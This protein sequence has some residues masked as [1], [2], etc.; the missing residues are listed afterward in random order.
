M[1]GTNPSGAASNSCEAD[2]AFGLNVLSGGV[3]IVDK[4][5]G[6]TSHDVVAVI[7]GIAKT[8]RVGHGGTLDPM[9][10]GVLPVFI[11]RATK[12]AD[13]SADSDKEYIALMRLGL[14]TDTQDITGNVLE[15]CAE[16]PSFEET[17]AALDAFRGEVM[18]LPPMYS[19]VKVGGRKLYELAR[20]GVEVERQPRAV[21]FSKIELEPVDPAS[22]EYRLR[23]RCSKGGYI[24]TLCHD[25]GQ[26]LGCGAVMSG[27]RRTSAAGLDISRAVTLDS[28]KADGVL[29]HLLPVDTL[30]ERY[31]RVGLDERQTARCVCG[32]LNEEFAGSYTDGQLLRIYSNDG[33]FLQVCRAI[34][35]KDGLFFLESV[36]NFY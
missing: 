18:Q 9:A 24:R 36:K 12:A 15:T 17:S 20:R 6:F 26:S 13:M 16:L 31:D 27:L 35:S 7:R 8:R 10:T 30:F 5:E 1:T 25:I 23:V 19:A 11:G 28:L 32:A 2:C 33:K 29:P 14:V 21:T 4:P 22:G 34:A 3:L